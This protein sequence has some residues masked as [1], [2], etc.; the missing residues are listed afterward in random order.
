[1]RRLVACVLSACISSIAVASDPAIEQG[2]SASQ[3][4]EKNVAARGGLEAWRKIQS[5]AWI[6]HVESANAPL[7]KPQFVLAQKRPNMTRFEIK[8]QNQMSLRVYDGT[9][10]W[11]VRP[12]NDGRPDLQPY[13]G[14]ELRFAADGQGLDGQLMDYQ[15]KGI[16]VAL[17][18]IEDI[19]GHK[20]YR[21]NVRLPSGVSHHLWIDAK[22][23][24]DIKYDR[25]Y[26]NA[27]GQSGTLSVFYRNYKAIDGLQI[28][29]VIES[30]ADIARA[31]DKMVIDKVVLNPPLDDAAF[32]KPNIPMSNA[33]PVVVEPQQVQSSRFSQRQFI[34]PRS[35]P[36]ASGSR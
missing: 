10:G 15:T 6:G 8:A 31:S 35:D 23:F 16:A 36:Y 34:P 13:S 33:V 20:A 3:I 17:D 9:H 18:G 29:L 14:E 30:G 22:T 5:M 7:L 19:E 4:V 1:M 25:E 11:K 2:L 27:R 21:L 26:R 32:A 28:P 24:L 12:L